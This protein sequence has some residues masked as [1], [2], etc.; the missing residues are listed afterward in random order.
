MCWVLWGEL[1]Q[2]V[3][4]K[5]AAAITKGTVRIDIWCSELI[6]DGG[7]LYAYDNTEDVSF[8]DGF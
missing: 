7:R 4:S 8:L 3:V 6:A 2:A 1:A 5:V